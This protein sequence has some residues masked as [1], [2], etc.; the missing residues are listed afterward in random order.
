MALLEWSDNIAISDQ[1][2]AQYWAAQLAAKGLPADVMARQL[3]L[4]ARPE[5]WPSM[6]YDTF[7]T[8]RRTLMAQ[9]VRDAFW[10]LES[11]SYR[12]VYSAPSVVPEQRTAGRL[13]SR[14]IKLSELP[15]AGLI[16]AGTV[17]TPAWEEHEQVAVVDE[18]GRIRID[19]QIHDTP[20]GA[21]NAAG[22]GTNG[23]TFWLADTP[24]GQVT[25]TDLRAALSEED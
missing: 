19:E 22:A 20:S 25:L 9:V 2:P 24:E 13:P 12:P 3:Y 11:D 8:A 15:D 21:A 7:L 17:L 1:A 23:W 6:D 5:D 14:R 18:Q 10:Q 4:H 16:S